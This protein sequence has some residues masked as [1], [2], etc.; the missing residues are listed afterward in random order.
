MKGKIK[1]FIIENFLYGEGDIKDDQS[2]FEEGIID[3][4]GFIT[5]LAFIE[6]TFHIHFDRSEITMENFSSINRVL[7]NINK[8][9]K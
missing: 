5:L 3:S 2:L 6:K 8:K 9:L 7:E 1:K 4:F